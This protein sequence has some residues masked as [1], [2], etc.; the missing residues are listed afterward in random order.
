MIANNLRKFLEV[1]GVSLFVQFFLARGEGVFSVAVALCFL[2]FARFSIFPNR[3]SKLSN[4]LCPK[5][6]PLVPSV[7]QV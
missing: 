7:Q 4:F 5:H 6:F 3:L 1:I 2:G